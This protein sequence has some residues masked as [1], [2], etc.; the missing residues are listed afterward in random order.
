MEIQPD[1]RDLLVLFTKH[2]VEYAIV[3]GYA[4]AFHGAPRY[5]GDLDL[6]IEMESTNVGR[7]LVALEEFGFGDLG[8]EASDLDKP[9][10][11]IQLGYPPVRVDILTL[12]VWVEL[13]RRPCRSSYRNVWGR[14]GTL[15]RARAVLGK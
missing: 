11:I 9:N 1:F 7:V 12:S 5:T 15:Y 6:L 4:L 10:Q 3:G 8:I 2:G 13:G 14:V